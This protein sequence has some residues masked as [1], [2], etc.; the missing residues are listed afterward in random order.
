MIDNIDAAINTVSSQ[1]AVLGASQ[2]RFEAV[3]ATLQVSAENQTAA[4]VRI[5]YAF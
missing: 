2:N 1:R 5:N 4:R 3:I